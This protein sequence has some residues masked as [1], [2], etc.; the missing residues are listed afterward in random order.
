MTELSDKMSTFFCQNESLPFWPTASRGHWSKRF[1]LSHRANTRKRYGVHGFFPLGRRFKE[2]SVG[3]KNDGN[4]PWAICLFFGK[5]CELEK[6]LKNMWSQK[7]TESNPPIGKIDSLY[8]WRAMAIFLYFFEN[9]PGLK[10]DGKISEVE[11]Y[12]QRDS[13]Y[14]G[15]H[16]DFFKIKTCFPE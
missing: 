6:W 16:V 8:Q 5:I 1:T 10:N 13:R 15:R 2:K 7:V 3:W 11:K 14:Q 9:I 12:F 4:N